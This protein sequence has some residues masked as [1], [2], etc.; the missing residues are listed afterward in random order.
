MAEGAAVTLEQVAR[1]LGLA[2]CGGPDSPQTPVSGGIVGD[3]LSHV[4]SHG[5]AGDCWITIQAHP[6]I[7]AVAALAG[8]SAIIIAD[9]YPPHE[10]TL[11]R[12]EE[13][14]IA[15]YTSEQPAF[16]LAGQLYRLGV[17]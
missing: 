11:L 9:G 17:R 4:M 16:A 8:F 7:V 3:L 5:K 15:I 14:Q 13:E 2:L 12:A 1:E 6:N 10:D